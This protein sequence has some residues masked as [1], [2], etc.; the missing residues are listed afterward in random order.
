M[1]LCKVPVITLSK[2]NF[3]ASGMLTEEMLSYFI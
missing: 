1:S 3:I 2:A